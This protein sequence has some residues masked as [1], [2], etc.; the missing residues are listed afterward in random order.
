MALLYSPYL[1]N[2]SATM[3]PDQTVFSI[4]H[5]EVSSKEYVGIEKKEQLRRSDPDTAP[6]G[7]INMIDYCIMQCNGEKISDGKH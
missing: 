3:D 6:G 5:L 7:Q 2:K 4:R 1:P